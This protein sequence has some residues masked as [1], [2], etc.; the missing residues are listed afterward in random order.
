MYDLSERWLDP[1]RMNPDEV[2]YYNRELLA[3][4]GVDWYDLWCDGYYCPS[5]QEYWIHD[6]PY[7]PVTRTKPAEALRPTRRL[8][9]YSGWTK[10]RTDDV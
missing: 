4:Y 2:A 6:D 8:T 7:H 5:C 3:E 9:Y 1:D 10:R